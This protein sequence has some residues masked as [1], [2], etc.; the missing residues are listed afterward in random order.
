MIHSV[1]MPLTL[2][3]GHGLFAPRDDYQARDREESNKETFNGRSS[4]GTWISQSRLHRKEPVKGQP[5]QTLINTVSSATVLDQFDLSVLLALIEVARRPGSE[6]TTTMSG[7]FRKIVF[8]QGVSVNGKLLKVSDSD[9]ICSLDEAIKVLGKAVRAKASKDPELAVQRELD[10]ILHPHVPRAVANIDIDEVA[11]V[12]FGPKV[13]RNHRHDEAVKN[14]MHKLASTTVKVMGVLD[15]D[16][17]DR[18]L[19]ST[20]KA[21]SKDILKKYKN[22]DFIQIKDVRVLEVE[23]MMD[24][25]YNAGLIGNGGYND[26][27]TYRV[28]FSPALSMH[29]AIASASREAWAELNDLAK[30]NVL[31][32]N[33]WH[34]MQVNLK[35]RDSIPIRNQR[36]RSV[37]QDVTTRLTFS[38]MH[39]NYTIDTMLKAIYGEDKW[40]KWINQSVEKGRKAS[41]LRIQRMR[42]KND[43]LTLYGMSNLT[44]LVKR[45]KEFEHLLEKLG[46][47]VP[48]SSK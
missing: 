3:L 4:S 21:V 45:R 32:S 37:Y 38:L 39:R 15:D 40:L 23:K 42:L 29:I 7:A 10:L 19:A 48:C 26:D 36:L 12:V 6:V 27:G 16:L 20:K 43:L 2:L 24:P 1:P 22:L 11:K 9:G 28:H 30:E 35:D 13:L 47:Q 14:S 44:E 31:N 18:V 17:D 41:I 46:I 34:S 8:N 5:G 25:Y 33:L